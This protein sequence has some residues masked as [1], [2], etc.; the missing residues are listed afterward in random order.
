MTKNSQLSKFI[1]TVFI[2]WTFIIGS[3]PVKAQDLVSSGSLT[4]G[5]SV[6]VARQP[7]AKQ[8]SYARSRRS[9]RTRRSAKST[10]AVARRK[11]SR[12]YKTLARVTRRREKIKVYTPV[13]LVKLKRETPEQASA[14]LT[15]GAQY[16]LVNG[17]N[18]ENALGMFKEAISLDKTNEDAKFGYSEALTVRADEFVEKEDF[19]NAK[20]F[21]LEALKFNGENS[22]AYAGL[23][24]V[25]D[26]EEDNENAIANYEKALKIDPDLTEVYAPLGI[27]Y[28]E[29]SEKKDDADKDLIAKASEY[30]NKSLA[31]DP[32]NAETQYFLGLVRYKQENYDAATKAFRKSL[33][34]EPDKP[35]AHF[36]LGDI[37]ARADKNAEAIAEY[38]KAIQLKPDYVDAWFNLGLANYALKNYAEAVRAYTEITSKLENS[39]GLAHANLAESYQQLKEWALAE[40]SYRLAT[41]F[42]KDDAELFSNLGFVSGVLGKWRGSIAALEE[43]VRI[44]ANEIDYTNLGW[45]YYNY[46]KEDLKKNKKEEAREKFLLAK[47][48]LEKAY[49]LNPNLEGALINLGITLI[50]L[51]ENEAAIEIL[52][53]AEQLKPGWLEAANELGIAYRNADQFKAAAEQFRKTVELDGNFAAGY[54]NWGEAEI[55]L[56]NFK[57]A[58]NNYNKLTSMNQ[59]IL[60]NRLRILL[61]RA[62]RKK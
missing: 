61:L 14:A 46:A 32:N 40:N 45:A 43:A 26:E 15:G 24:A 48:A 1:L 33:E 3:F 41:A 6:F 19:I 9:S 49:K 35:E 55:Q 59:K 60:A 44:D 18:L 22:A 34:I 29:Q 28:I 51:D 52:K 25:Y 27:L 21:Y 23:G 20:G 58:E 57:Q 47:A 56:G 37:N 11:V 62:K 7:R 53:K 4:G 30:L 42:I 39:N 17:E 2:I 10:R 36:Y 8:R 38:N 5:S 31:A 50:E 12:Q 54:Y 13:E 16:Y